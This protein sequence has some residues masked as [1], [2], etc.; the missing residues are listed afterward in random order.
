[1]TIGPPAARHTEV[2]PI[3]RDC[4]VTAEVAVAVEVN[5]SAATGA[6]ACP[7]PMVGAD[8]S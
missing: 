6:V 2:T 1:M 5:E 3:E 4:Q 8:H 7:V